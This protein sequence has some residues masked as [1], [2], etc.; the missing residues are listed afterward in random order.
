MAPRA[1]IFT[2]LLA[3]AS[4]PVSAAGP[5]GAQQRGAEAFLAALASMGDSYSDCGNMTVVADPRKAAQT[6]GAEAL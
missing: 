6:K 4:F 1:L 5:N 2:V 3:C